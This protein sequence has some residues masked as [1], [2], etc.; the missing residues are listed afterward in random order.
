MKGKLSLGRGAAILACA[1]S[2]AGTAVAVSPSAAGAKPPTKCA[3][4]TLLVKSQGGP[5]HVPVKAIT[6]DGGIDCAET[7]KALV[8]A[9]E[10]SNGWVLSPGDF[11][12]PKGYEARMAQKGGKKI[13]F[14]TPES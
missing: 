4:K 11:K 5:V 8:G 7:Y 2:L 10:V 13:E 14:A 12:A 1:A 6:V 3:D 9:M